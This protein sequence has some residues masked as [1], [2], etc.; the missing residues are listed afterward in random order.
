M[1]LTDVFW[2][3][4][5]Q[6]RFVWLTTTNSVLYCLLY[7]ITTH[8]WHIWHHKKN[9]QHSLLSVFVWTDFKLLLRYLSLHWDVPQTSGCAASRLRGQ[10]SACELVVVRLVHL[11]ATKRRGDADFYPVDLLLCR[12]WLS[13]EGVSLDVMFYGV[14]VVVFPTPDLCLVPEEKTNICSFSMGSKSWGTTC[15]VPV[16]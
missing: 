11:T 6:Q 10:G 5:A 16:H 7:S 1:R 4:S 14:T 12:G 9:Y 15:D 2:I 8:L 3:V 13:D